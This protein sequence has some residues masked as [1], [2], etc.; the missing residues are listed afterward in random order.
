MLVNLV[1]PNGNDGLWGK[2]NYNANL[3]QL[4]KKTNHNSI[5]HA[6]IVVEITRLINLIRVAG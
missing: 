2:I 1:K 3:N 4:Q 6:P 5:K